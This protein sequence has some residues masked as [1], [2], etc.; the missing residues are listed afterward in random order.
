MDLFSLAS[1]IENRYF[2]KPKTTEHKPCFFYHISR[3]PLHTGS[4]ETSFEMVPRY[5]SSGEY[6]LEQNKR[7]CVAPTIEQCINAIAVGAQEFFYVYRTVRKT[8]QSY[9]P[10]G[11]FDSPITQER[12]FLKGRM[13]KLSAII[14]TS[15]WCIYSNQD[16]YY[17]CE[18]DISYR[19][20]WHSFDKQRNELR[21][22]K[23]FFKKHSHNYF[24]NDLEHQHHINQ[25]RLN[26]KLNRQQDIKKYIS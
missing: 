3:T 15:E 17:S 22:M 13:F 12:W 6:E 1:K 7:I 23:V 2:I 10:F 21:R 16:E 19:G 5:V 26:L 14:P 4:D 9:V 11:V 25:H 8:S 18:Y 24:L 20:D